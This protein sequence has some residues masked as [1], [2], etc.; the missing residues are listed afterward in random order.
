M[1]NFASGLS[2]LNVSDYAALHTYM[3]NVAGVP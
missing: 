3:Q 1:V 2:Y